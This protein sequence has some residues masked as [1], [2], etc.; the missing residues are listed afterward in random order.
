MPFIEWWV[1]LFYTL[2]YG[3]V[4]RGSCSVAAKSRAY[5][6]RLSGV[7]YRLMSRL[8]TA[9]EERGVMAEKM[10]LR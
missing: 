4:A 7:N 6:A 10:F 5:R 3:R 2:R 8:L 1:S 9:V